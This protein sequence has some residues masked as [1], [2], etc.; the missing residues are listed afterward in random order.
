MRGKQVGLEMATKQ[1]ARGLLTPE[2]FSV[3]AYR[4]GASLAE[5]GRA[6]GRDRARVREQ[7]VKAGFKIRGTPKRHSAA[8]RAK[9]TGRAK[10]L[11]G[12]GQSLRAIAESLGMSYGV[13]RNVLVEAGV[14]LRRRGGDTRPKRPEAP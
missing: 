3:R 7:L 1:L 10:K 2:E 14:E 9:L 6:I 11:Y 5:I 13:T 8:E 12:A 4:R